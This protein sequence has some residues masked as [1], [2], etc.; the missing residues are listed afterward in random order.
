MFQVLIQTVITA[1]GNGCP[2]C[3]LMLSRDFNRPEVGRLLIK[4]EWKQM[5]NVSIRA[6]Q[7]FD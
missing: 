5:F 4:S 2:S 1:I 7:S 6:G 3:S